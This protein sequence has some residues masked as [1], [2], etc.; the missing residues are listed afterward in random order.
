M[1]LIIFSNSAYKWAYR[2]V[3][4]NPIALDLQYKLDHSVVLY[5]PF[6]KVLR[7]WGNTEIAEKTIYVIM[8]IKS[9]SSYFG[10]YL[11]LCYK[12]LLGINQKI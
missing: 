1:Y 6:C 11:E 10:N 4:V 2:K 9:Y 7:L 12:Y 8:T 5:F 3:L